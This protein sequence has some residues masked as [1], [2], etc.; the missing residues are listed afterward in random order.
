MS[1]SIQK[2]VCAVYARVSLDRQAESVE[3]QVSLLRE[4]V[5][6]RDLGSIPDELVYQDTGVSATK[7]S[8]WT[9][10]AMKRLLKDAE[11]GKFQVVLFKGI[12]R[13]ARN[14]QEA[15]DVLDRLKVKGLRVVSYE[16]SFDSAKDDSNFLFT[17]HSAVAEYES[18]KTAIRVRLGNK[19]K[20]RQGFWTGMP[21][22]GYTLENR[23][24]I[25]DQEKSRIVEKIY[26][27]YTE[28]GFGS[29]KIAEYLNENNLLKD[30]GRLWSRKTVADVLK[31]EAYTGKVVY[32]KTT[33]K[34][35]RDYEDGTQGK[36]KWKRIINDPDEWVIVSDAHEA[37]IDKETF[38][39]AKEIRS[40]RVTREVAP[41]AYHPLTGILF[42]N[43]CGGRM[44][45]QK[46]SHLSKEYRYYIC[47]TYHIYGRAYCKQANI[48]GEVLE[49]KVI[50]ALTKRLQIVFEELKSQ[51]YISRKP[52]KVK[53]T[54]KEVKELDLRIDKL[55]K[56]HADLYFER[57]N[58]NQEQYRYL[59][60]RIKSEMDKLIDQKKHLEVSLSKARDDDSRSDEL[61]ERID[62]Y[63]KMNITDK[64]QLRTYLH[65]FIEKVVS[66]NNEIEIYYNVSI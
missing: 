31:N 36:K 24:L 1:T 2:S 5:K 64:K 30:S 45:C 47:Q 14:T 59:T 63:F 46:R 56:D 29:F 34:R 26:Q 44:M 39:R 9:R 66:D 40:K 17:I 38:N 28:E 8:L 13:F 15:L 7:H 57:E 51:D 22:F 32:N 65:L 42:C 20:A 49:K 11:E 21:P 48:N 18:E 4:F 33:Q 43:K 54:E 53:G 35:V 55:N 41:N 25:K 19:E 50:D 12:S 6:S 62:E 27:M 3:H 58:M 23:K 60:K 61:I 52:S 10:P 37:I 16:E